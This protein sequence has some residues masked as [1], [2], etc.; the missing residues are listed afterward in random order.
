MSALDRPRGDGRAASWVAKNGGSTLETTTAERGIRLPTWD[1]NNAASVGA[2][3]QASIDFASGA[4]G[5]VRVLQ[6]DSLRIDAIW[7]DEFNALQANPNVTSIR[8]INPESGAEVL[9][10]SR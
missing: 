2:W 5:N 7:K 10:W 4:R 9:L 1:P 3:R 6:G 8:S